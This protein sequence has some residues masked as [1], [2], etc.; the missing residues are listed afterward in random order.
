MS[1]RYY[2]IEPK[3]EKQR[4]ISLTAFCGK[5][6]DLQITIG[7]RYIHLN[8]E[9][10]IELAMQILARASRLISATDDMVIG[11]VVNEYEE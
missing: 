9:E 2:E 11:K 10:Q 6:E 5:N 3:D 4:R 1:N 8:R 7:D